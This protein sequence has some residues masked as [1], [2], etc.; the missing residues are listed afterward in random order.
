M[1]ESRGEISDF[2]LSYSKLYL[3]IYPITS[4]PIPRPSWSRDVTRIL[5]DA[6]KRT[7]SRESRPG[8]VQNCLPN[9]NHHHPKNHQESSRIIKDH[10]ESSRIIKDHQESS[11]IT[12]DHQESS[13]IIKNHQESS[14]I[15]KNDQE[16]S[17]T[18]K[19]FQE[20]S[21][22]IRDHRELSRIIAIP[23]ESPSP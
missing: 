7:S 4:L 11:R 10:Q 22:I 13:R 16:S 1:T 19:N 9:R 21:R 3:F 18:I 2:T 6:T 8:P 23:I 17:R 14:R 12:K 15:I 5:E 20:S